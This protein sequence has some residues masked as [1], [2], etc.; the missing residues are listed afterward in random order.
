LISIGKVGGDAQ[1]SL[2]SDT[3]TLDAVLQA[4]NH[5]TLSDA[6]RIE[7]I[8]LDL[9]TAIEEE[10]VSNFDSGASIGSRPVAELDVFVL[11]AAATAFHCHGAQRCG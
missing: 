10:V 4:G 2:T 7:L 1:A 3:H 5:T 8:L 11:D 6:K 9:L